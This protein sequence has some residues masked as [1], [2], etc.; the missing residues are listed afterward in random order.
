VYGLTLGASYKPSKESYLRLESRMLRELESLPLF[1]NSSNTAA[2][3]EVMITI[4]AYFDE[5]EIWRKK[6]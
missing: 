1:I 6:K 4:G 3:L 5:L 2:R